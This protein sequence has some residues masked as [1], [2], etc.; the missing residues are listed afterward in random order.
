MGCPAEMR[1]Y[2]ES[3]E[4]AVRAFSIAETECRRLDLKY[5]H[6]RTDSYLAR[7]LLEAV[8]PRGVSVDRE[9]ASLLNLAATQHRE[10]GGRFDITAGRLTALWDR[11]A[12]PPGDA[13]ISEAL[14]L[15]GWRNVSWDGARLRLPAG[16]RLDLGGIV[17]EYAADRV[18]VLLKSAG[19]DRGY[20]DLG[21]DLH[22]LGPHP[23]GEA[24][25]IG[26]KNP[27][28]AGALACIA[29]H[30]GGL[31]TSGDY[32]RCL[33]S[34]GRRYGH[35]IDPCTG[36]PVQGLAS[37]SV[38]APAC[39]LAGAVCTMAMLYEVEEGLDFLEGCGFRWL[40]HDGINHRHS[41][42]PEGRARSAGPAVSQ[43]HRPR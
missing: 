21:G 17:K 37:V 35:I 41:G 27:R 6:F 29:M 32:E 1:I 14:S 2:S 13:E 12:D 11:R 36:W 30:R 28:G 24:W 15:T 23:G 18:A 19:F 10:S 42:T 7:T 26:I 22:I 4:S 25:I 16:F 20:V 3:R 39:L 31:A 38:V 43:A 9:T 8:R 33:L 34:D 40:A 5:S